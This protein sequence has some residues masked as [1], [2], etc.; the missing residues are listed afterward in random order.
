MLQLQEELTYK[1]K[2]KSRS[3]I[4]NDS[5]SVWKL[6]NFSKSDFQAFAKKGKINGFKKAVW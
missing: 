2:I 4:S 3:S 6:F 1:S 5:R